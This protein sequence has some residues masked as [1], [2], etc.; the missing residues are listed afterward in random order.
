VQGTLRA[1]GARN[2]LTAGGRTIAFV[3]AAPKLVAITEWDS[4]EQLQAYRNS[5][6]FNNLAAQRDKAQKQIRSFAVESTMN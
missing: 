5:A 3:G 6:A 4:L 1:A 2:F